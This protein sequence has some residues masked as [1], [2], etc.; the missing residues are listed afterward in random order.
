MHTYQ[1]VIARKGWPA[2]VWVE[3]VFLPLVSRGLAHKVNMKLVIY[4]SIYIP[5]LIYGHELWHK[6]VDISG[7]N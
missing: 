1:R 6:T 3:E 7:R 4:C 5:N 2:L